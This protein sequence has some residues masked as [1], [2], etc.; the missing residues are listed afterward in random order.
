MGT[1]TVTTTPSLERRS[2]ERNLG[3][4][5]GEAILDANGVAVLGP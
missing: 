4:I 5:S 3:F 1:M 2:I